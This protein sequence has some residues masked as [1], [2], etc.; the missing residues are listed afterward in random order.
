MNTDSKPTLTAK[1]MNEKL[2]RNWGTAQF[3]TYLKMSEK[4]F[5]QLLD[6]TFEGV[7]GDNYRRRLKKNDK[8]IEQQLRR[9]AVSANAKPFEERTE[10]TA[11]DTETEQG[12]E[13]RA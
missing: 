11:T 12:N 4:E 10:E 9:R 7:V 6:K 5:K 2:K 13:K 8:R 1:L 3:A